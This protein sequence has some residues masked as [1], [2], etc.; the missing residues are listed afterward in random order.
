MFHKILVCLDHSGLAEQ[1]LPYA[2]AQARQFGCKLVLINVC[3]KDF[4]AFALPAS[5]Q[6]SFIPIEFVLKEFSHRWNQ[7][8]LYL[9]T[10]AD[11]LKSELI[12]TETVVIEGSGTVADSISVYA[13]ENAIDLIAVASRGRKGFKR[14]IF[15]SVAASVA[16]KT[17]IP[18][19]SVKSGN[20]E[21]IGR[22]LGWL[23]KEEGSALDTDSLPA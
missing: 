13:K 15:G 16:E 5:G 4:N 3:K 10:I 11:G 23:S 8:E 1:V 22:L 6:V 14:L 12:D 19:L 7:A 17:D 2:S 9:K 18:V 21:T 20:R